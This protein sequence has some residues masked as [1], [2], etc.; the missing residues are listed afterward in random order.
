MNNSRVLYTL[1]AGLLLASPAF[2]IPSLQLGPGSVGTWTY[3]NSTQTWVTGSD[4]FSVDAFANS[5]TPGANGSF[6]WD[7]AGAIDRY[8]YLVVSAIPMVQSDPL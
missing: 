5:D 7:A 1:L 3:D 2:G 8:A 6:A 4:P